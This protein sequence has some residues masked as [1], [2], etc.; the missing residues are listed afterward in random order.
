MSRLSRRRRD[1]RAAECEALEKPWD[2]S[3]RGFES[4]SLRCCHPLDGNLGWPGPHHRAL[5]L[6]QPDRAR[7]TTDLVT[8]VDRGSHRLKGRPSIAELLNRRMERIEGQGQAASTLTRCR[9]VINAHIS[10]A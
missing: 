9:P 4:L 1:G 10:P 3:P 7:A 2:A 5:P 6:R 8:E